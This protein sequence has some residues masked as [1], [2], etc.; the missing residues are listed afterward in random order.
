MAHK[1]APTFIEDTVPRSK[2]ELAGLPPKSE[3]DSWKR[4]MAESRRTA[5]ASGIDSLWKRKRSREKR[6]KSRADGRLRQ[7]LED[8]RAPER[9][10]EVFTRGTVTQATLNTTVIRDP[11]YAPRQLMSQQRTAAINQAKSEARK[12]SVQRL[13][14]E[15][16]R[17]ILTEEELAKKVNDIFVENRFHSLASGGGTWWGAENMWEAYGPPIKV[18]DMF[19][20]M[21]GTSHR[22]SKAYQTASN[23]T[24][25]RQKVVAGELTGGALSVT[26]IVD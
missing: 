17:F 3:K 15:A 12:D 7:N 11:E 23:K 22:V 2:A 8:A 14:V 25:Q 26:D 21:R 18:A 5:L 20:D 4:L 13:Y 6:E 24:A 19:A 1:I 9:P 16:G 10:D